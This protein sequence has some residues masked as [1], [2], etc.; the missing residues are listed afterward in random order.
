MVKKEGIVKLSEDYLYEKAY[1][2]RFREWK[3]SAIYRFFMPEH[4]DWQ[5]KSNPYTYM[6]AKDVFSVKDGY[7]IT[8]TNDFKDHLPH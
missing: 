7:Y 5:V 8:Q 3:K 2:Q 4:A 1:P 6:D